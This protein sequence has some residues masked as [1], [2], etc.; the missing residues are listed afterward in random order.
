MGWQPQG[1]IAVVTGASSGIGRATAIRLARAGMTVVAVA[2]REERL[3][4][5]AS[6]VDGI[7]PHGAD[8]TDTA[9]IDA[10][11]ARVRDDFGSCHALINNAG[12]GGGRFED[13]EHLDDAIRTVDVNLLG[14]MRC[15]A[16]FADLLSDSAPSRV[17]NIASVAGKLGIGPPAYAASK[18]GVVGLSEAL[19]FA[20]ASRGITVCQLNPGF[21]ETEGFPQDQIKGSPMAPLLRQPEDVADAVLEVLV[22]GKVERTVP[23]VYRGFVVTR[24]VAAPVYR[25]IASRMARARGTRD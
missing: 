17:V 9:S 24:H 25:A 16:A 12:V 13:R 23:R 1:K 8:V 15:A 7:A 21:I 4:E 6:E 11:A 2:R 3:E 20:W 19:S 14:T 22:E 5:L 10:L 18:F